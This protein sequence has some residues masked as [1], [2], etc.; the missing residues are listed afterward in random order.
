MEIIRHKWLIFINLSIWL[1]IITL[2]KVMAGTLIA[3]D[4]SVLKKGQSQWRFHLMPFTDTSKHWDANGN[5]ASMGETIMGPGMYMR[6]TEMWWPIE[7]YYGITSKLRVG[8]FIPYII[9]KKTTNSP[10]G[11]PSVKGIGDIKVQ[12]KYQFYSD[13]MEMGE[14]E[15]GMDMKQTKEEDKTTEPPFSFA[16]VLGVIL[17]AGTSRYNDDEIVHTGNGVFGFNLGS[18]FSKSIDPITLYF[19]LAYDINGSKETTHWDVDTNGLPINSTQKLKVN[20]GNTFYYNLGME[21]MSMLTEDKMISLVLEVNGFR[22]S[23]VEIGGERISLN[24]RRELALNTWFNSGNSVLAISPGFQ[25][26][27]FP[28]FMLEGTVVIDIAGKNI[29]NGSMYVLGF[30]WNY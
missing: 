16:T 1:I 23:N 4:A 10:R 12:V 13:M 6:S 22:T 28:G 18:Y 3:D 2:G 27:L 11:N 25:I 29:C 30:M 20:R 7:Y 15:K 8:T 5:S 19:S 21:H 17:P 14:M 24:S 26:D 9:S